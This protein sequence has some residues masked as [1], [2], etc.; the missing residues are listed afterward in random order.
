MASDFLAQTKHGPGPSIRAACTPEPYINV[1][2]FFTKPF[3]SAS[4]FR[5]MRRIVMNESD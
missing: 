4:H 5:E 2:D 1:A 3:K